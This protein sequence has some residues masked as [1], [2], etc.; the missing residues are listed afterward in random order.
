MECYKIPYK[1]RS[2]AE[3]AA[4]Q[5]KYERGKGGTLR[6]EDLRPY[7]CMYCGEWHLTSMPEWTK[8][9]AR[10]LRKLGHLDQD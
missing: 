4:K 5:I 6:G 9:Q 7:Q 1:S 10:Q 8:D 2:K 3:R